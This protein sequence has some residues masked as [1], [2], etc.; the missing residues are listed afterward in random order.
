MPSYLPI[1][2]VGVVVRVD[3]D[4]GTSEALGTSVAADRLVLEPYVDAP[5]LGDG[6]QLGSVVTKLVVQFVYRSTSPVL[7][8]VAPRYVVVVELPVKR[9]VVAVVGILRVRI[10]GLGWSDKSN[11]KR[12]SP[13]K[14]Y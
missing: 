7:L 2:V 12:Y 4:R 9:P 11:Q 6:D 10:S 14:N 8:C 13:N 1:E 3:P 5:V